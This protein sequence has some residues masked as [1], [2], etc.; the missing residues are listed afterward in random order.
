MFEIF[1]DEDFFSKLEIVRNTCCLISSNSSNNFFD[2]DK[3]IKHIVIDALKEKLKDLIINGIDNFIV[4]LE[5]NF[6]IICIELLSELKGEYSGIKLIC[7]CEEKN[8]KKYIEGYNGEN[9]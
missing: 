3:L 5:N 9:I 6:D 1:N 8:R 2:S 7:F 4:G